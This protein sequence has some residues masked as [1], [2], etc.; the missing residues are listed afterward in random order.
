MVIAD[1]LKLVLFTDDTSMVITNPSPSKFKEDINDIID[2][3]SDW[4]GSNLSLNFDKT[5]FI[6]FRP[7]IVMKLI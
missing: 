4:V 1:L 5:Y 2:N 6:Q 3:T 7:K